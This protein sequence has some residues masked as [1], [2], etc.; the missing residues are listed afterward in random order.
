QMGAEQLVL[1]EEVLESIERHVVGVAAAQDW[2][3]GQGQHIK[4]GVLL[5]GPPGT[6]KTHTIRYLMSRTTEHTV[7]VLTGGALH[8]IRMA[9]GLA[10][11]LQPSIVVCE[12]VD[13]VA[14]AR[15][16]MPGYSNPAL[17]EMLNAIDGIE[18]DADITFVL[19]TRSE[20]RR[21]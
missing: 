15:G 19:T 18:E 2:L 8:A 3:R 1:P 10:R 14:Q 5:H 12:D 9:V 13:L 16:P 17:F 20:E 7:M 6:G 11:L 21:V 4:R